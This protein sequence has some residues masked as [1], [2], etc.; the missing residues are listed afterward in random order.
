M[1]KVTLCIVLLLFACSCGRDATKEY[2]IAYTGFSFNP[3]TL[4]PDSDNKVDVRIWL[5]F[6]IENLKNQGEFTIPNKSCYFVSES[7]IYNFTIGGNYKFDKND[8]IRKMSVLM[9]KPIA[10]YSQPIPVYR[11]FID[12]LGGKLISS[13]VIIYDQNETVDTLYIRQ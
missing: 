3:D 13:K 5:N 9:L 2:N 1:G 10:T 11:R 8:S 6:E 4:Y 7:Y 12:S